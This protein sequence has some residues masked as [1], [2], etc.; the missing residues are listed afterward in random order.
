[1]NKISK[2]LAITVFFL[3]IAL[4]FFRG[5]LLSPGAIMG[6][7]WGLPVTPIQVKQDVL[8][9]TWTNHNNFLGARRSYL[10][11]IPTQSLIKL[12]SYLGLS[13]DF[14]SKFYLFFVF[15]L[16]GVSMYSLAKFLKLKELPSLLSG[17]FYISSP[18]F[19]DYSIMGWIYVLF[20]MGLLPFAVRYFI[21]A[22]EENWL[23]GAVLTGIIYA[24]SIISAQSSISFM[25]V[26]LILG[27]Y[28]IYDKNSFFSYLKSLFVV[29]SIF[30]L[31]N[32]HWIL[33]LL[34]FPDKSILGS[35]LVKSGP[36]LGTVAHM[37]PLNIIRLFGSL[38]NYQYE[39][40]IDTSP[41]SFISFL[42]PI[43]AIIPLLL[44]KNKRFIVTLWLIALIPIL[45][46]FLNQRRDILLLIPMANII[47]DFAR[48]A[49]LSTFA[50]ALLSAFFF[51]Y[52][53][54]KKLS[55][56][57]S[58]HSYFLI[59]FFILWTISIFPWWRGDIYNWQPGGGCFDTKLRTKVIPQEYLDME[60]TFSL[61][62]LDH[63]ALYLPLGA[64][65]DFKDDV[66]FS[67][68]CNGI[69]D[70]FA[71]YSPIP[72]GLGI[73]DRSQGYTDW[74]SKRIVL[75][76]LKDNLDTNITDI[77]KP[78]NVKYFIIRKNL[79]LN[80]NKVLRDIS[81]KIR[82][83]ELKS[84]IDGKKIS[85][86]SLKNLDFLP[87]VY[88]PQ[89]I[90]AGGK[91]L[92][93]IPKIFSSEDYIRRT[94]TY[95]NNQLTD[96]IIKTGILK[97]LPKE[98]KTTPILEFK[99]INLT[100]YRVIVHRAKEIFP[101]VFSEGY[102]DG[103][104]MYLAKPQ[105]GSKVKSQSS[106]LE[107][108]KILDGNE[109]DQA[110]KE[111]LKSFIDLGYITILGNKQIDFVSKNFQ[112]TIQNDNLSNGTIWETWFSK[113]QLSDTNH[114]MV[115]S[116]ANSWLIDISKICK[117]DGLCLKNND[118]SS[119]DFELIIEF[120]PQ[121]FFYLG[122]TVSVFV[123]LCSLIYLIGFKYK[124]KRLF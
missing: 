36:S 119:Y 100:K 84:Y 97:K 13:G 67:G 20:A 53:F 118:D 23:K 49:A 7:D 72:G 39:K 89:R 75:D 50:Y 28:L 51:N 90:L 104:K 25:I 86:Y 31:L 17:L 10:T 110:T 43:T 64:V 52:L 32:S 1:M 87:H 26:F 19:F 92:D 46:Y 57:F 12:F 94:A 8:A 82:G 65:I 113:D 37:R 93:D 103:W 79:I 47:R 62:K 76:S 3:G 88:T 123:L 73:S 11:G 29:V 59:I 35:D 63:K 45:M 108:Y 91:I 38:F 5:I 106:K 111:E 66:K 121:K 4:F 14:Y 85:I 16:A 74:Y 99:K 24:F 81:K 60:K 101:L 21:Q 112:D 34:V 105:A 95:I 71:S 55:G 61:K 56:K 2:Y 44:K 33:G 120:L 124:K 68:M 78:T 96:E 41:F 15:T 115:N 6:S 18:I 80:D 69:A 83:D 70:A 117:N 27:F 116:Y 114:L 109:E 107:A 22:V 48:F 98:T 58:K 9:L 42:M 77:V 122:L 54:E 40:I 30:F 102:H